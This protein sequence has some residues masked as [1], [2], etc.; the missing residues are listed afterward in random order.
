MSTPLNPGLKKKVARVSSPSPLWPTVYPNL[1][2]APAD[3]NVSW[4]SGPNEVLDILRHPASGSRGVVVY[5]HY[6]GGTFF[7]HKQPWLAGTGGGNALAWQLTE[8]ERMQ[9]APYDFVSVNL[10]Q[11]RW[12]TPTPV[13]HIPAYSAT[14][15]PTFD[16]AVVA[17]L[18]VFFAWL[19]TNASTYGWD[20]SKLHL[21]GSSRGG[22]LA[23]LATYGAGLPV[24]SLI[25]ESPIPDFRGNLITWPVAECMYGDTDQPT[26]SARPDADKEPMS[27]IMAFDGGFLPAN[28][29]PTFLA[30][31]NDG[32]GVAP[33]ANV[34]DVSQLHALQ[35]AILASVAP[36]QAITYSRGAWQSPKLGVG[37]SL[38]AYDF[39]RAA[40]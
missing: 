37:I 13:T 25:I 27:A 38:A 6:G 12:L 23:M 11:L 2:P 14:S 7:D 32:D 29:K 18:A 10:E 34:H 40:E 35:A 28:Y 16:P 20:T 21:F 30:C 39:L 8:N 24:K 19:T 17:R 9:L 4:G 15:N 1:T 22:W 26:W 36:H 31:V 3:R 5:L 33:F